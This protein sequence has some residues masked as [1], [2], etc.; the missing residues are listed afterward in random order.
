MART[1]L[2]LL[3][4]FVALYTVHAMAAMVR[5]PEVVGASVRPSVTPSKRSWF[6]KRASNAKPRPLA[7]SHQMPLMARRGAH[8][9]LSWPR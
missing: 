5:E 1:A 9:M 6:S 7:A 2:N 4:V 8:E 3:G